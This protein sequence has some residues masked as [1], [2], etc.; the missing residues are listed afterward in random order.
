MSGR[1]QA[2]DDQQHCTS[3]DPDGTCGDLQRDNLQRSLGMLSEKFNLEQLSAE[4]RAGSTGA[5]RKRFPGVHMQSSPQPVK[6]KQL[7]S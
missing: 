3:Q 7:L 2:Q 6:H 1:G 5:Q 4:L